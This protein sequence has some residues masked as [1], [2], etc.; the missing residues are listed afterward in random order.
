MKGSRDTRKKC[1][2]SER[3][4]LGVD[5]VD[6]RRRGGDLVLADR[7]PGTTHARIAQANIRKD[8][9]CNQRQD[10]VVVWDRGESIPQGTRKSRREDSRETIGPLGYI[11]HFQEYDRHNFTEAKS[12]NC[13][14]I[15]TQAECRR[16][17]QHSKES[18]YECGKYQERPEEPGPNGWIHVDARYQKSN[19]R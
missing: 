6:A 18:G 12:H 13:Q 3:E 1:A 16:A 8:A 7:Y 15:T 4:Q 2:G 10:Q 19:L 11:I 5:K 14:V 17:K 9:Q